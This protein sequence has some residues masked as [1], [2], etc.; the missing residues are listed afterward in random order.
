MKIACVQQSAF[1]IENFEGAYERV[2]SLAR[3]GASGGGELI[4]LPECAYPAYLL[5]LDRENTERALAKTDNLLEELGSICREYSVYIAVGIARQI[6]GKL[7]NSLVLLNR[8]G[9]NIHSTDKSNLWHFDYKSFSSGDSFNVI[10]TDFGKVGLLI[11]ADGRPPEI[12]RILA[13]SGAKIIID[14]V[15]LSASART[16]QA[17]SNPQYAFMLNARAYENGVWWIVSDK[18][19]LEGNVIGHLGR[20]MVINPEGKRAAELPSAG[21]GILYY[22]IDVK[23]A[24]GV[25]GIRRPLLYSLIAQKGETAPVFSVIKKPLNLADCEAYVMTAQFDFSDMNEYIQKAGYY[26]SACG[27]MD[28]KLLLLPPLQMGMDALYVAKDLIPYTDDC[29]AAVIGEANGEKKC[30]L[31]NQNGFLFED[32]KTHLTLD[33]KSRGL[34]EGKSLQRLYEAPFGNIGVIFDDEGILPEPAR[35]K[36]LCGCDILLWSGGNAP[37][38]VIRTRAAENK[39]YVIYSGDIETSQSAVIVN[40][41]GIE[42]CAAFS[43]REQ[44]VGAMMYTPCSRLKTIVPGTHVVYGR[45]GELYK[46]LLK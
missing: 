2:I 3:E 44:G 11:C 29:I 39:M 40:P 31:F 30:I 13:L 7:Y 22:D 37:S 25:K 10:D 1:D 27:H 5:G 9:V 42:L 33:E 46:R 19:G 45:R 12:A 18:E 38:E 36:M 32:S 34:R 21:E 17:L 14:A 8:N 28:G 41:D 23:E 26:I 16:P 6:D 35:V 43:G 24:K 4:V 15:N 20:S